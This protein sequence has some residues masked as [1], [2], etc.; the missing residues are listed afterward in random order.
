MISSSSN[1]HVNDKESEQIS[2]QP[3]AVSPNQRSV[4]KT[5][6]NLQ[7]GLPNAHNQPDPPIRTLKVELLTEN[8]TKF[9]PCIPNSRE[10]TP[11]ETEFFKGH[12]M[13]IIRTNPMDMHF[14]NFFAGR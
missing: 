13:I 9:I 14:E 5:G 3:D 6:G 10:P 12:A 11:F 2:L 7:P 4:A 1:N 8:S